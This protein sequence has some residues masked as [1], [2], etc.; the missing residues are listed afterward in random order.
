MHGVVEPDTPQLGQ[1]LRMGR[2]LRRARQEAG[3]TVGELSGRASVSVGLIS[4]LERGRGNPSFLTLSRLAEALGISLGAF[5]QGP[6]ETSSKV[7][8]ARERKKLVL[9]DDHLVYELLTPNLRG[10]LEMLRTQV[11]PGWSNR[12]RPFAHSGEECVH[13]VQGSL[14]VTVGEEAF[15][16]EEGDS[17]TYDATVRHWWLNP[18]QAPAVIVGAVTPPSF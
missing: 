1:V 11:P 13:L 9:P 2:V 6:D 17:I 15:S 18:T 14:D 3:L 4:Q 16:L 12:A 8:R 7:V 10:N 5:V